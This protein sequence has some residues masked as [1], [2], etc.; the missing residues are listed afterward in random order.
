MIR[1]KDVTKVVLVLAL[2]FG[3]AGVGNAD[4]ND[5]HVKEHILIVGKQADALHKAYDR[6]YARY[7]NECPTDEM[8]QTNECKAQ[9]RVLE[10]TRESLCAVG[11]EFYKSAYRRRYAKYNN[12]CRVDKYAMKSTDECK[13]QKRMLESTREMFEYVEFEICRICRV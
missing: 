10:A 3:F 5:D 13:T 4:D 12:E 1:F 11:K 6:R 7:N 2:C 8:K 9:K